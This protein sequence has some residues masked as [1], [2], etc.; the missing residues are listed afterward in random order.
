L[1][2]PRN[3]AFKYAGLTTRYRTKTLYKS[4]SVLLRRHDIIVYE[5]RKPAKI[6]DMTFEFLHDVWILILGKSILQTSGFV[7]GRQNRLV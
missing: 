5:D 7:P 6:A 3:A 4:M 1:P 2:I